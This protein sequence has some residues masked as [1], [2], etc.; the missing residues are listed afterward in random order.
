[1]NEH[2]A[3]AHVHGRHINVIIANRVSGSV[4]PRYK[5]I[6]IHPSIDGSG[7][8]TFACLDLTF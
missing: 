5:Y 2:T 3:M 1:M 4:S 7:D 6:S 8:D